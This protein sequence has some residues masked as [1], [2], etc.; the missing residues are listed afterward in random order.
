M[1]GSHGFAGSAGIPLYAG[2]NHLYNVSSIDNWDVDTRISVYRSPYHMGPCF[3][4]ANYGSVTNL[5][6]ITLSSGQNANDAMD[7][8]LFGNNCSGVVYD[9]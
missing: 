1:G 4:I 5:A 8:H 9:S 2:D 3:K 6:Y 7:S